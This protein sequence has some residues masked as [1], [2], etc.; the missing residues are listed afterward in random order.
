[1]LALPTT[2]IILKKILNSNAGRQVR[3]QALP[4]GMTLQDHTPGVHLPMNGA[5]NEVGRVGN[6]EIGRCRRNLPA[7]DSSYVRQRLWLSW[8][9][10][11]RF[12]A[13]SA[14]SRR[15]IAQINPLVDVLKAVR[16][17][18]WRLKNHCA[19]RRDRQQNAQTVGT[20][21]F[22]IH[23]VSCH[24]DDTDTGAAI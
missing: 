19:R 7:Q 11:W 2:R 3:Q 8:R 10:R 1:M 14:L 4:L 23:L 13:P 17:R 15:Q 9:W 6:I 21:C 12:R 24:D 18:R 20:P 16:H 22:P 5:R